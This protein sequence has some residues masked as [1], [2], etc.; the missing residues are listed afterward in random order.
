MRKGQK[1]GRT[2]DVPRD[3]AERVACLLYARHIEHLLRGKVRADEQVRVAVDCMERRP[4]LV[5]TTK[6]REVRGQ[7]R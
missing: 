6:C 1:L 5:V 4:D 3:D 7:W 2:K